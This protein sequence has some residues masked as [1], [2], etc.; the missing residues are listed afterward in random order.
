MQRNILLGVIAVLFITVVALA[1]TDDN[2]QKPVTIENG[3]QVAPAAM[4]ELAQCLADAEVVVYGSE[5][6][7]A[8]FR[9]AQQFGG[10]DVIDPFYVECGNDP[11][12]CQE[13]MQTSYVPEIQIQ[14]ELFSGPNAPEDLAEATNCKLEA[15][16]Q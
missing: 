6:C 7:P 1:L 9:F 5:T 12:A 16:A 3:E 14:G 13:N 15:I 8:C 4:D 2:S 10:Y 11:E